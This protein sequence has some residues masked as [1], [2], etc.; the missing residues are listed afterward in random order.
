M[1]KE[2]QSLKSYIDKF[3]ECKEI[4]VKEA[5]RASSKLKFEANKKKQS[6][7]GIKAFSKHSTRINFGLK[8]NQSGGKEFEST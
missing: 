8:T 4:S 5:I 2:K 3:N 6:T 7:A 1:V